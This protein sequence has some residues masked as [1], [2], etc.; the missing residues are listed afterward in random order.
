MVDIMSHMHQYVAGELYTRHCFIPSTQETVEVSEAN[1]LPVVLGGDQLTSARAQKSKE[2][3]S[4]LTISTEQTR[5]YHT[6]FRGLAH[7]SDSVAGI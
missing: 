3:I 5:W 7:E 6:D 2:C 1:F 4:K